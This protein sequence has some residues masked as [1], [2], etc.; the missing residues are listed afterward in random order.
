M[1]LNFQ[2]HFS[3]YHSEHS[4][5][6]DRKFAPLVSALPIFLFVGILLTGT[7]RNASSQVSEKTISV[8]ERAMG[9]E[10]ARAKTELHMR[11]LIDPFFIAY[12]VADQTRLDIVASNGS[13]SR[14]EE[15]HRRQETVRLLV[16][17]YQLNDENFEDNT[18]F[19][20]FNSAPDNTLPLDDDYT[21]IRRVLWLSTDDLFKS[22]NENFTKK[23]AALEHKQLSSELKDLPDF[24]KA[25]PIQIAEAPATLN[26]DRAALE[27]M[28]K[29]VSGIFSQYPDIQTSSIALD[30]SNSYEWIQNT[31][32]TRVRK[33]VTLCEIKVEASTQ[34]QSDGEPLQLSR[35]FVAKTPDKL[36]SKLELM[37]GVTALAKEIVALRQAPIFDKE[38]TGPVLFEDEA[39]ADYLADNVLSRFTSHREDIFGNDVSAIF[40][41]GKR[42]SLKEKL[43]TRILP[44]SVTLTDMSLTRAMN[45]VDLLGYYPFDDEGVAPPPNMTLVEKGILKTLYMTRTPTKE[46]LEPNGHARSLAG[47]LPGLTG[48]VPAPGVIEYKDTKSIKQSAMH[49]E[50]LSRAKE[51]GYDYGL[52]VRS[53]QES[54]PGAD[55]GFS[56]QDM[57]ANGKM[58]IPMLV[59]KVYRDG[60]EELVRGAEIGIPTIRDLR[61]MISSK[62]TVTRNMLIS[63]GSGGLF[64]FSSGVPATLIGPQA[65][66]SPELEVQR[67]KS[68]AYPTLPVV[69]RP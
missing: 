52:I 29:E 33:P 32:G 34:A 17:N 35:L 2:Q 45:G 68:E 59:Y 8:V 18:G 21:G 15:A 51:D 56:L 37:A 12:V 39:A 57:L 64:S 61:E 30:I 55:A 54:V 42:A 22:A 66:L 28:L 24:S 1:K 36:P 63:G 31:E 14:S 44:T 67:K 41:S 47:G 60:H 46:I 48:N 43:N 53:I 23:Q 10:L 25:P 27:S 62:E 11:G 20:S 16:N 7:V 65:I 19:F 3:M 4:S 13:L 9:D 5:N 49:Q 40:A 58:I 50:L 69:A 6:S 26:Y 38:Y